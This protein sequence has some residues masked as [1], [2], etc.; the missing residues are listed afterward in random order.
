MIK[1]RIV[2]ALLVLLMNFIQSNAQTNLVKNPSFEEFIDFTCNWQ[3]PLHERSKYWYSIQPSSVDL[4]NS[5]DSSFGGWGPGGV[6]INLAG[7]QL[8]F[9]GSSYAGFAGHQTFNWQF[10][11]LQSK[12]KRKLDANRRY[13]FS[14]FLSRAEKSLYACSALGA[15]FSEDSISMGATYIAGNP[16]ML[17]VQPQIKNPIGN[18]Y[19]S[20]EN[21][22]L[23]EGE[24]VAEGNEQYITIGFFAN[25]VEELDTTSLNYFPAAFING[26][27]I[28][29]MNVIY[30][31][32]DDVSLIDLDSALSVEE[33]NLQRRFSMFPNPA[34]HQV[35]ISANY[36][37]QQVSV[38]DISGKLLL[39]RQTEAMQNYTLNTSPLSKGVYFVEVVF[40]DGMRARERLVVN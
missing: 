11:Y 9:T 36:N 12:L 16:Y 32:I 27:Y 14:C 26:V 25:S 23:F 19:L 30:Y 7:F 2:S 17:N 31:Y 20:W 21:W 37:L 22:E 33:H 3:L 39:Q 10:E 35:N 13:R 38:F 1:L 15:Y 5:C 34:K 6:P 40:G 29:P 28:A 4:Y 24:F 18:H 8:P